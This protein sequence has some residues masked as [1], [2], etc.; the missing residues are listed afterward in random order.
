[1]NK[2]TLTADKA[3][4]AVKPDMLHEHGSG[5]ASLECSTRQIRVLESGKQHQTSCLL[6]TA[7]FRYDIAARLPCGLTG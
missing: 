2:F 1:M 7:T 6:S 5:F 3:M 4:A